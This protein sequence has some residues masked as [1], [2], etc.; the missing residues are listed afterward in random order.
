MELFC[1]FFFWGGG[2]GV[3]DNIYGNLL[4]NTR[5]DWLLRAEVVEWLTRSTAVRGVA[6]SIPAN[7]MHVF[8]EIIISRLRLEF[9][10]VN[11][12]ILDIVQIGKTKYSPSERLY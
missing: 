2:G 7:N 8:R 4:L 10:H 9:L 3:D 11:T 5:D 12:C 1:V 6:G